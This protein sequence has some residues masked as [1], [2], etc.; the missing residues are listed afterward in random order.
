VDR[1]AGIIS[2]GLVQSYNASKIQK[3]T[4]KDINRVFN[5]IHT[6]T[7]DNGNEFSLIPTS[8]LSE[9]EVKTATALFEIS[10]LKVLTLK[11]FLK[12]IY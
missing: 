10:I 9:A 7:Y 1:L 3:Q 8:Y 12:P 6:V 2:I 11:T 4:T 5:R